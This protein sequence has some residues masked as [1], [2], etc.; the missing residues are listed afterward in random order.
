MLVTPLAEEINRLTSSNSNVLIFSIIIDSSIFVTFNS[1][2]SQQ[3]AYIL[4]NIPK[5]ATSNNMFMS[6]NNLYCFTISSGVS[7]LTHSYIECR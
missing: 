2:D 7:L 3:V 6:F 1:K 4:Q 5:R